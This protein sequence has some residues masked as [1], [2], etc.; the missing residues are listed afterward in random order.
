MGHLNAFSTLLAV[1]LSLGTTWAQPTKT[2]AG[3]LLSEQLEGIA[4]ASIYAQDMTV[5]GTTD[6]EG[7]FKLN[8][9]VDTHTLLFAFV[10]MERTTVNLRTD[11]SFLEVIL[12]YSASYD[13]R[14]VRYVNRKRFKRFKRLP[15]LQQQAYEK[16]LFKSRAPCASP[17]FT[18][19]VPHPTK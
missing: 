17:I 15:Q 12:L 5:I 18:K 2:L 6:G 3:R 14:S 7:Y 13:F 11:C 10:G 19:W 8:V 16:G 4:M 1:L 9:P